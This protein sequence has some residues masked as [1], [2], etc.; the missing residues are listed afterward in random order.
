MQMKPYSREVFYYE[1]DR[2]GIVHHSNYIRWLEEA[3][4]DFMKQLGLSYS[5][6]EEMGIL[7]PVLGV[8]LT[9]KE[10]FHYGDTFYVYSKPYEYSG[11][12]LKITY[13][14]SKET[15]GKTCALGSSE[16]CFCTRDMKP[17][18]LKKSYPEL[19]ARFEEM[20]VTK[21]K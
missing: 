1:T 18:S 11:V 7:I 19:S 17:M 4:L 14:L 3:R 8:S 15:D 20:L 6:M 21:I 9:Y 13:E 2:M 10:P 5:V 16:H 12:K